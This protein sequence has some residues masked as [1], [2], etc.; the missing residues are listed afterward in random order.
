MREEVEV[1]TAVA[2]VRRWGAADPFAELRTVPQ[3]SGCRAV[4]VVGGRVSSR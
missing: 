3:R 1:E 2:A 4:D